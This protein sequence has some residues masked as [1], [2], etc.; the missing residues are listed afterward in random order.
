MA[1]ETKY[2]IGD[3]VYTANQHG[4]DKDII[5]AVKIEGLSEDVYYGIDGE[6]E[7]LFMF[8]G[9]CYD[10]YS[11]SELFDDKESARAHHELEVKRVEVEKAEEK[12]QCRKERIALLKEELEELE[13][14]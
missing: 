10:W 7:L 5:K 9:D 1:Y 6:D 12:L 4:Y 3:L 13:T 8:R 14:I 11:A 2:K